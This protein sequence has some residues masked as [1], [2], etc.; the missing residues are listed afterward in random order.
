M[1]QKR[2]VTIPVKYQ[3]SNSNERREALTRHVQAI[4]KEI[5]SIC[6]QYNQTA[7]NLRKAS[8][9]SIL[10]RQRSTNS[11]KDSNDQ[12]PKE[13]CQKYTDTLN[14]TQE[15]QRSCSSSFLV[16]LGGFE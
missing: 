10:Q 7:L 4:R 12:T 16:S 15:S 6:N 5:A 1:P 13:Y 11:N 9:V 3:S 8:D 2:S 14:Q